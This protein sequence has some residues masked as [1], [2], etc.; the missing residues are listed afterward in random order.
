[1]SEVVQW[2]YRVVTLGSY[3]KGVPDEDLEAELNQWGQEGWELVACRTL[4]NTNRGQ[5][6]ARRPLDRAARR[7]QTMP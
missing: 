6:V 1:M 3:F 2:E 7:R 5:F 4:E